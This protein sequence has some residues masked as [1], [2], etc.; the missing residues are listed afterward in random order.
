MEFDP[1]ITPKLDVL[2]DQPAREQQDIIRG[3]A[4]F[5]NEVDELA[6]T[7]RPGSSGQK[8]I[9]YQVCCYFDNSYKIITI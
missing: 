1:D 7:F 3:R 4:A 6:H 8:H 9:H 5:L 2:S